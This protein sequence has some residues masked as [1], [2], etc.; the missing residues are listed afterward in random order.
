MVRKGSGALYKNSS[1]RRLKI[2]A[3]ISGGKQERGYRGGTLNVPGI[4]GFGKAAWLS[5]EEP[6]L[7]KREFAEVAE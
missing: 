7:V 1:N 5:K 2:K 4:V 3:Q 6:G